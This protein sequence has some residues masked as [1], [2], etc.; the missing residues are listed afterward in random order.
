[1]ALPFRKK[2][3]IKNGTKL[4]KGYGVDVRTP[5]IKVRIKRVIQGKPSHPNDEYMKRDSLLDLLKPIKKKD[6]LKVSRKK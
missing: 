4:A 3:T 2:P 6:P 1:M 5:P